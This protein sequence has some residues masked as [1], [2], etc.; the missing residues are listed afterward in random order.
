MTPPPVINIL[1][2]ASD[3]LKQWLPHGVLVRTPIW[4]SSQIWDMSVTLLETTENT[5]ECYIG[6]KCFEKLH[7]L[8]NSVCFQSMLTVKC[9][10]QSVGC[11]LSGTACMALRKVSQSDSHCSTQ[12]LHIA[13]AP[14]LT[15]ISP[16]AATGV[17]VLFTATHLALSCW[18]EQVGLQTLLQDL[19]TWRAWHVQ[20]P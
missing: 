15:T 8:R 17:P 3:H 18:Y 19:S 12:C 7:T 2:V 1:L 5:T 4:L 13:T 10:A 9:N 11:T 16:S 14:H 20:Q 6:C